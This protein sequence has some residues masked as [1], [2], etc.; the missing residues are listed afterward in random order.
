LQI[1][2]FKLNALLLILLMLFVLCG[3]CLSIKRC[4]VCCWQAALAVCYAIAASSNGGA[5][6]AFVTPFYTRIISLP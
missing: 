6:N 2:S 3:A 5:K 1:C 4:L